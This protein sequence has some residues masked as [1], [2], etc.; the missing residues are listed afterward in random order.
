MENLALVV[1][2]NAIYWYGVLGFAFWTTLYGHRHG[3]NPASACKTA[4]LT[5]NI[6]VIDFDNSEWHVGG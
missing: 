6:F 5:L 1:G 4:L 3:D 2:F